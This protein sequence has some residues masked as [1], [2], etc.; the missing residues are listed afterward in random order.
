MKSNDKKVTDTQSQSIKFVELSKL[1]VIIPSF[2]RQEFLFR[3]GIYWQN[4]GVKLIFIDGSEKPIDEK[5]KH[6]LSGMKNTVYIHSNTPVND[7]LS[8][9]SK[10]LN[11]KYSVTLN[12]D[13]FLIKSSLISAIKLLESESSIV[14]CR[15]QTLHAVLSAEKNTV[16]YS[17]LYNLFKNFQVKHDELE[18]RLKY[19]FS[20]YNS[21]ASF[22][23]LRSTVWQETW[24]SLNE[25][26]SST[27]VGEFFQNL[28]TYVYGKLACIEVPYIITTNENTAINTKSDN[29]ALLFPDWWSD[30]NYLHE[31]QKFVKKLVIMISRR[32]SIDLYQAQG[33]VLDAIDLFVNNQKSKSFLVQTLL[34]NLVTFSGFKF[35]KKFIYLIAGRKVYMFYRDR[36]IKKSINSKTTSLNQLNN[37]KLKRSVSISEEILVEIADIE[38]RI[39]NFHK[40]II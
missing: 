27:N 22:A 35:F 30:K 18:D 8:R 13:D 39:L 34:P 15:G 21:A 25:D 20:N 38:D 29:R 16:R 19:A 23:V 5:M 32:E 14:A 4:S 28:A 33:I 26:Y 36:Y 11:T 31:K 37:L 7:R 40:I 12:D 9:V 24:G 2:N 17:F 6:Y 3:Q 1:T 10:I